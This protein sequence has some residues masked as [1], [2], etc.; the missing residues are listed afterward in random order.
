MQQ[1]SL[2]T[3]HKRRQKVLG[4]EEGLKFKCYK[5]L[6]GRSEI[7]QGQNSDMGEG[8]MKN[9]LKNSYVFYGR[10]LTAADIGFFFFQY[11]FLLL[12]F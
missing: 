11:K 12:F 2:G 8:G 9:G 5:K 4:G 7:N 10:P 6:E 1:A 3:I